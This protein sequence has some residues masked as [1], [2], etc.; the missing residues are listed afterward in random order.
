[1]L[2][3]LGSLRCFFTQKLFTFLHFTSAHFL[4]LCPSKKRHLISVICKLVLC[5]CSCMNMCFLCKVNIPSIRKIW[6][7][8]GFTLSYLCGSAPSTKLEHLPLLARTDPSPRQAKPLHNANTKHH[9]QLREKR[10]EP[11]YL[12]RK[13]NC[14][15]PFSQRHGVTSH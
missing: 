11:N 8:A 5:Y 12:C 3:S 15:S 10:G 7:E 9:Y 14:K 13:R 1:M 2:R 6:L 4:F